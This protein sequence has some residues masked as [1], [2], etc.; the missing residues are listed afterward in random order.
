MKTFESLTLYAGTFFW[1]Q[2][3]EEWL[4]KMYL[5]LFSHQFEKGGIA[6]G[7]KLLHFTAVL[8]AV[9]HCSLSLQGSEIPGFEF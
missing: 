1:Q 5:L 7:L 3:Y 6:G 2:T 4:T 8:E 9:P